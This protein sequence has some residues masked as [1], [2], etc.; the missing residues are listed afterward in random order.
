LMVNNGKNFL[1]EQLISINW[2]NKMFGRDSEFTDCPIGAGK[3]CPGLGPFGY[4]YQTWRTPSG[5]AIFFMG[6]YGQLIFVHPASKTVAVILSA[7][8]SGRWVHVFTKE[9]KIFLR[10][11]AI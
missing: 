1:G 9:M 11:L 8:K 6:K 7:T 3:N 10:E 5:S 2:M 4:T